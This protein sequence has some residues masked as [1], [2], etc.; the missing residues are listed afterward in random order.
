MFQAYVPKAQEYG[1]TFHHLHALDTKP[2]KTLVK[3]LDSVQNDIESDYSRPSNF[4][5]LL[6]IKVGVNDEGATEDEVIEHVI[7]W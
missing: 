7:N 1:I 4:M 6:C 3:L 5:C 2:K